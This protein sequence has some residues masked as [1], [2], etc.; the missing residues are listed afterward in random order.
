MYDLPVKLVLLSAK[1][2]LYHLS[3]IIGG[4]GKDRH[5]R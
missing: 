3:R 1:D 5:D 4:S 2:K